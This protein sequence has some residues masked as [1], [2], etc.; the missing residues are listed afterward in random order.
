MNLH[1]VFSQD[2]WRDRISGFA[3]LGQ[4][5]SRV[6]LCSKLFQT[7]LELLKRAKP[8]NKYLI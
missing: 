4:V 8:F 7:N 5:A 6:W 1:P 3:I 2:A